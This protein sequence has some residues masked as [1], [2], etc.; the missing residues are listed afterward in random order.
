[1]DTCSYISKNKKNFEQSNNLNRQMRKI[2]ANNVMN[3]H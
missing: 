3:R 2:T 1:M